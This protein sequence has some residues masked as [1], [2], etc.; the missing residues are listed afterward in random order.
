[1]NRVIEFVKK[2]PY[3]VAGAILGLGVLWLLLRNSG[4]GA[5]ASTDTS[6]A[7]NA[8]A[9][10]AQTAAQL[11][12]AQLQAQ[13]QTT[14]IQAQ[15]Q[16]A[17]EQVAGQVQVATLQAQQNVDI[18][19]LTAQTSQLAAALSAQTTQAVSSLQATVANNQ[20]NAQ[21]QMNAANNAALVTVA[22]AP[23][24]AAVQETQLN[25]QTAIALAAMPT[26]AEIAAINS[27]LGILT[28]SVNS[29]SA[30]EVKTSALTNAL[31]T[32]IAEWTTA[33]YGYDPLGLY[34]NQGGP[35]PVTKG[36]N[37]AG[38]AAGNAG[39]L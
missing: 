18:A 11:Q 31:N 5:S 14:Q 2:H 23:Y 39:L 17:S 21:V 19:S 26:N 15:A 3:G 22:I 8:Q 27:Q 16:V 6:A 1:M 29:L 4:G 28:G 36:A 10:E 33:A 37:A 20:T 30:S 34:Y 35:A 32:S 25:D 38:T 24:T 9:S 12:A 13:Q 7:Y